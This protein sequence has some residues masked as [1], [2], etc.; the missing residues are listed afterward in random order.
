[1]IFGE[2]GTSKTSL[3]YTAFLHQKNHQEHLIVIDSSLLNAKTWKFLTNSNNGPLVENNNTLLFKNIEQLTTDNLNQLLYLIQATNLLQRNNVFFTY[4][5]HFTD[6]KEEIFNQIMTELDCASVY[7]ASLKERNA[8]LPNLLPLLLNRINIKCNCSV[9]GFEP[10]ALVALTRF[11]W[12]RNFVQLEEIIK[13]LVLSSNSYYISE[14]QVL[15]ILSQEQRQ[16]K[17]LPTS[18]G[19]QF[20]FSSKKTL[21]DYTQEIVLATLEKNDGN[22]TKTAKQLGISRTTLWRYLKID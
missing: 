18:N 12:P 19:K 20:L 3:A 2:T 10:Q 22:Q 17:T 4:N 13:K 16:V 8:E 15:E 1:M 6:E 14:H 9:L 21:F 11:D 5:T 7:A